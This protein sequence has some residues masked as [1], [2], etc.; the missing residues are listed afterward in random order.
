MKNYFLRK[1]FHISW[2]GLIL[3][4]LVS[5]ASAQNM[6]R[7]VNDFDGDG[8][9]DLAVTR[10]VGGVKI[11]HIWQSTNGYRALQ[12]GYDTDENVAGDYDGDGKTDVAVFRKTLVQP[13]FMS[14]SFWIDGSQ[15]GPMLSGWSYNA[16]P[17]SVAHHQDYNG[18]G[19]TDAAWTINDGARYFLVYSTGGTIGIDSTGGT[20]IKIGD[21]TGDNKADTAAYDSSNIV[22]IRNSGT[23]TTQSVHF[24]APGDQYVAADFDGDAKGDLTIFRPSDG[25]WW[26]M[27][28]SDN[29]I[30]AAAWGQNGDTPVPADYDNDGK[31]DLAIYRPGPQS[32]YWVYGS[33]SGV[34][35]HAWGITNDR[36]VTY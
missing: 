36:A 15:V 23:G 20:L 22:R 30:N 24:G 9:A 29:V 14:Y 21:M 19:K 18:D 31:T 10:T 1:M 25:T 5:V 33:Q 4:I 35:V 28:S 26:W 6:F 32:Y 16:Y 8:K 7:K 13:G 3:A 34:S 11:W 17:N 12:Y 27:R 2:A